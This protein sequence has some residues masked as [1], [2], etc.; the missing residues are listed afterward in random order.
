M[1]H[2]FRQS[3]IVK[4]EI[5][6]L[7]GNYIAGVDL[8]DFERAGRLAV[9][10]P[11]IGYKPGLIAGF[12]QHAPILCTVYFQFDAPF[13]QGGFNGPFIGIAIHVEAGPEDFNYLVA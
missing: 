7:P 13:E 6:L 11:E 9:V 4:P 2:Q 8:F 1:P 12:E 3:H 5:A 10:F